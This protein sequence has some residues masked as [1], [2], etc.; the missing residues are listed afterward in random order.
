MENKEL[1]LRKIFSEE[2]SSCR[3]QIFDADFHMMQYIIDYA[4][5]GIK[6]LFVLNGTAA[7][8]V[9]T[10]FTMESL[11]QDYPYIQLLEAITIFCYGTISS[12]TCILF[13]Y[14]TQA[15]YQYK[16]ANANI[17][18]LLNIRKRQISDI[19]TLIGTNDKLDSEQTNIEK[20]INT[21]SRKI[22]INS[23]WGTFFNIICIAIAI[24]SL[25][26]FY[27]GVN[28]VKEGFEKQ[29]LTNSAKEIVDVI[30]K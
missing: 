25:Y 24:S 22:K 3:E 5:M 1:E 2:A 17:L 13:A 12:L 15:I 30:K 26:C 14:F 16:V 21:F 7:I 18:I 20:D 19:K 10:L 28:S 11:K 4:K 27:I 23:L 9:L 6:G 8:S 29:M